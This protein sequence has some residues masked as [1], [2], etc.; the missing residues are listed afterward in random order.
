MRLIILDNPKVAI[1][2]VNID[3]VSLVHESGDWW[4]VTL[5]FGQMS[6]RLKFDN[7]AEASDFYNYVIEELS[8]T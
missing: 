3:Y 7:E 2:T 4:M 1:P 5:S 6:H 8:L